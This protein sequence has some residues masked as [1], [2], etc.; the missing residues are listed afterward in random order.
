[1]ERV[2]GYS[3]GMEGISG[4]SKKF[5]MGNED[6]QES[7]RITLA[8]TYSNGLWSLNQP[9]PVNRQDLQ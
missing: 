9:E 6:S 1:M 2:Q 3:T 7:M 4:V 5:G 8:K